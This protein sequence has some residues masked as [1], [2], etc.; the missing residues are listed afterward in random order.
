M[1]VPAVRPARGDPR[2][3]RQHPGPH[4]CLRHPRQPHPPHHVRWP[5]DRADLDAH[6]RVTQARDNAGRTV[7]YTY[8]SAGRL[9]TVTDPAGKVSSY[10]YDGTSNRIATA[11]DAGCIIDM[12][13]TY[14]ADGRIQH[15]TLAEGQEYSFAHTTTGTGAV[16][17]TKATQP[18]GAVRRVEFDGGYGTSDQPGSVTDALGRKTTLTYD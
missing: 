13:N 10:T 5:L 17:A 11:K 9:D 12:S 3:L 6:N 16:T 8:D 15:Q 1:G 18:G 14:N 4:P 2:P 7:S